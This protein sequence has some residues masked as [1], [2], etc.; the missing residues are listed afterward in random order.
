MSENAPEKT[1]RQ[2]QKCPATLT[3]CLPGK[4]QIVHYGVA[5]D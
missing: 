1:Q 4:P 2:A 5:A 3:I